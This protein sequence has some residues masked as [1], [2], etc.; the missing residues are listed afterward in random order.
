MAW[1]EPGGGHRDPWS[2]G[3]GNQGPP[4]LDEIVRK[5]Q[6]RLGG[7]FGG[8]RRPPAAV[9][10]AAAEAAGAP[11]SAPGGAF[12]IGLSA[13]RC[14]RGLACVRVL[15]RRA[16]RA[17]RGAALRRLQ[18]HY[19]AG[20]PLAH[21]LPGGNGRDGQRGR[22]LHLPSQG[23]DADAGRE[24]RRHRADRPVAHPGSVR[25]PVPGQHARRKPC[26][27]RRRP[28]CAR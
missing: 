27:M 23:L 17:R 12:G 2:G 8:K 26:A 15:R 1:N 4:D 13:R 9:S 6:R 5:L 18:E 25:L 24:H 16:G 21:S 20:P 14:A 11:A 10:A 7:L 3:G 28:R 19:R 22:D